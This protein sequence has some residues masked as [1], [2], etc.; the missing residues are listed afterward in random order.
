MER[1]HWQLHL[2]PGRVTSGERGREERKAD[3]REAEN[4]TCFNLS[5]QRC[6]I[7]FFLLLCLWAP[8]GERG[9]GFLRSFCTVAG[10]NG[11]L[12]NLS[13]QAEERSAASSVTVFPS[14]VFTFC[15]FAEWE[16][17]TPLSLYLLSP[18]LLSS[19]SSHRLVLCLLKLTSSYAHMKAPHVVCLL[20][21]LW[22][23]L[24][25]Q[26]LIQLIRQ[27]PAI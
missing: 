17:W 2:S 11:L 12:G 25:G 24:G 15:L 4:A 14:L 22:H 7:V 23:F 19:R 18:K 16:T 27:K 20:Y 13:W 6:C 9:V 5:K 26:I 10:Q 1:V 8:Q 21:T 3:G